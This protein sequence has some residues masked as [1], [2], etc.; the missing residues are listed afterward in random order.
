MKDMNGK[1]IL[2]GDLLSFLADLED[3][4]SLCRGIAIGRVGDKHVVI[5]VPI[6]DGPKKS[7]LRVKVPSEETVVTGVGGLA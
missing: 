6:I 1:L 4:H 3:P 5:W 7:Y 2:P